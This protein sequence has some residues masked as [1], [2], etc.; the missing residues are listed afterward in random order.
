M[1]KSDEILEAIH[2]LVAFFE[3]EFTV[4]KTDIAGLKAGQD[5]LENEITGLKARLDAAEERLHGDIQQ[6]R[7]ETASVYFTAK[8]RT[9]QV[10]DLLRAHMSEP[11]DRHTPAA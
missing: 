3:R 10:A 9:D 8:G 6:V 7:Y 5:R 1:D 4:V 11:H 2:A